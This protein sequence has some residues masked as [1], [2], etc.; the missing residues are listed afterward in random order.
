MSPMSGL[1]HQLKMLGTALLGKRATKSVKKKPFTE[2]EITDRNRDG[3]VTAN[4][5][6]FMLKNLGINV[7]DE[8]IHDLI[9]EASHSAVANR[10]GTSNSKAKPQSQQQ[11]HQPA[12]SRVFDRDGNGF[13][14]RDEL[15][16]AMEMIGEPLNEQQLEQLLAIA[17][18]DQD[19][20]INYEEFT[21]LL[22]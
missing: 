18:L 11:K 8:I 20:R 13:I 5:L 7:R 3:R 14:T 9:R 12:S 17:D 2:V 22:L 6:Q 21:R 15:Q 1:R 19:G 4:E 16:T 10:N